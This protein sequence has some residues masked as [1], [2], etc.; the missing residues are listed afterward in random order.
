VVWPLFEITQQIK[1]ISRSDEAWQSLSVDA[2][3]DGFASFEGARR[4][5]QTNSI[6]SL[7]AV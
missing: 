5:M 4:S 6:M 3:F 2:I 1:R 7:H